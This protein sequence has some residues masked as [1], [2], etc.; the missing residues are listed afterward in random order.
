MS[1]FA[2]ACGATCLPPFLRLGETP[3]ANELVTPEERGAEQEMFPL[4]VALCPACGLVQLTQIVP[5][6]RLFRDYVY[7]SS[8]ATTV[9]ENARNI[10]EQLV[11]ERG[12]GDQS[13]AAEIA[14]NDGYLLQHYKRLG[15]PV[16]GVEPARNIAAVAEERGI[17]TVAEFFG[18]EIGAELMRREGP[19]DVIHANNVLAHVDDLDGVLGGFAA[20]LAPDGVAVVEA[21]Y[22]RDLVE[23]L[24]FDTIYHEHIYYFSATALANAADRAGLRLVD[25][26]RIPIHGGSLRAFFAL[27]HHESTARLRELLAEEDALGI[28]T[29]AYVADFAA[30]VE[31]WR[32]VGRDLLAR[33]K[34]SGAQVAAYGASAKGTTLLHFL[35]VGAETIDFVADRSDVKQGLLTPGTHLP[36]VA[37][38]ALAEE[39]PDYT[40]L[41]TWNF[42]REIVAQQAAYLEGGGRFIVPVPDWRIV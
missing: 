11:V 25:V 1:D 31:R 28:T 37:P 27:P 16:L 17:R 24:E 42:E 36:I 14:S 7:F 18:R 13:L 4:D 26:E 6:E 15:V 41:L 23:K 30:R 39:S 40:L 12:L 3:L 10:V 22:L 9:V 29:P 5:R 21:P 8:Y 38:S 2:C 32:E 35:G 34:K 20:W 33:L 19:A